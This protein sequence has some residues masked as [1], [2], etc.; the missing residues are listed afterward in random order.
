MGEVI[1]VPKQAWE[2][3]CRLANGISN[4]RQLKEIKRSELEQLGRAQDDFDR[5]RRAMPRAAEDDR[6]TERENGTRV[7]GAHFRH[8][9]EARI[10]HAAAAVDALIADG[11]FQAGA[12]SDIWYGPIPALQRGKPLVL[13]FLNDEDRDGFLG[14][15]KAAKPAMVARKI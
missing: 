9:S 8:C 11:W 7:I 3:A 15:V 2:A 12:V 13:Y 1:S 14:I 5:A 10:G 6:R 4:I